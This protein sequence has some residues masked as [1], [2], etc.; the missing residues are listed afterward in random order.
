MGAPRFNSSGTTESQFRQHDAVELRR[1]GMS[2]AQ[3]GEQLGVDRKTAWTYVQRALAARARETVVDR[4]ALIGEQVV[5]LDTVFEGMLPK[6]A[7]GDTRAAEIVIRALDRHAKLFGLDAPIRVNAQVTDD[8]V[9]RV[10]QL[11][12]Q[13]AEIRLPAVE[14]GQ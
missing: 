13:L 9:A 14:A 1:T 5:I 6:A 3:I 11:A 2:Y 10:M 7:L 12:E 4:D 8:R